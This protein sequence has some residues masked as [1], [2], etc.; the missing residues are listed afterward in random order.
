MAE[1]EFKYL[2]T[3][4]KIGG[5]TVPN[6]IVLTAAVWNFHPGAGEPN[7]RVLDFYEGRAKGGVGL[8]I[9]GSHWVAWPTT[10]AR[11][12]AMQ[13]DSVI[14]ALKRVAAAIHKHGARVFGQLTHAG[15]YVDSRAL[16]GGSPVSASP[17]TRVS[18]FHP[19]FIEVPHEIELHDIKRIIEA[20]G[21]AARRMKE[22][23]Y[24][25][26]EIRAIY[27][28]LQ[29]SF[30]SS[31]MNRRTDEYGGSP[32]NQVRFLLETI[33]SIRKNVGRDFVVGVRFTGDEFIDGGRTLDESKGLAKKL[34][35]SGNLDYLFPCAAAYGPAHIPSMYYPLAAFAYIPAV[36]KEVISLPVFCVGRI[37]DPILAES[38][39]AN[40][41]ADMIGMTRALVADP[42]MPVKAREGRLDEIR[43]CIGCNEG[44]VGR[45]W[46]IFLPIRCTM[47][48]EFG[49]EKELTITPADRKKSVMVIGGGAA[50]LETAR[51]AALRGHKLSLYEKEQVLAKELSIAAKSPGREDFEEARRYYIY[52]MKLLGVDV[53]LGVTV[54]PEMVI[55]Q[56][57]DAVVVATG[58]KP[59]I[60]KLPGSEGDN[61]VEMRQVLQGEVEVGHNVIVAD[62]QNH[63]YGLD[64]AAFLAD[65]GKRVELLTQGLYAGGQVDYF[66][67]Q[68][69]YTRLLNQGVTITP[70]T[71]VTEIRGETVVACNV[72]TGVER[73]IEGVDSVVFA[74]DGV[75]NDALYCSLKGSVRELYAA[76]HCVSPRKLLDSI[77]D[78]AIIGRKL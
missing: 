13:S 56:N 78:G 43:R 50:G 12:T 3:P 61:V 15:N 37:N 31:A 25:G 51:V 71:K 35:A 54:T 68:D 76:G 55:N 8:I 26:V 44:C 6:R 11:P 65:R 10:M 2:F 41:Q 21:A 74:T 49:R 28:F 64:I 39:L 23:G 36:I 52:Q 9:T 46:Q 19:A 58:A 42:E 22:A 33:D 47:N 1:Q 69:I 70:L 4:L 40:G 63:I 5:I 20:Y 75:A 24:D 7:E 45:S 60:P 17:I 38:I 57:A 73:E 53:H 16:G 72:L 77:Y 62:C 59:F 27:G 30:L 66:T 48:P 34:K 29:A 67:L 14:P 32:E 18:P